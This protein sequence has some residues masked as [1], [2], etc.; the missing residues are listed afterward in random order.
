MARAGMA[1]IITRLRRMC[2]AGTADY[3]IGDE[4]YWDDEHLQDE[5][6]LTKKLAVEIRLEPV[7]Q[8]VEGTTIYK[9]YNVP[10]ELLPFEH[11][12]G[13]SAVF[14]ITDGGGT[15][16]ST[17]NFTVDEWGGMI[18]F[19]ADQEASARYL[20]TYHY[21]LDKV[22]ETVWNQKAAHAWSAIDFSAD[23]QRFTR[24]ALYKHA[25][26]MRNQYAYAKGLRVTKFKRSDQAAVGETTK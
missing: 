12:D 8:Y 18:M 16:I 13:G 10:A 20:T 26:E 17:A 11:P 1:S 5:L 7:P 6:D 15:A 3:S 14:K 19:V 2:E 24:S 23:G 4:T 25:V 21:D 9:I 22:A